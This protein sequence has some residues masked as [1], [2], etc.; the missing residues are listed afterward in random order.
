MSASHPDV[1]DLADLLEGDLLT[2]ERAAQLQAHV[3]SCADCNELLAAL[4]VVPATLA[5]LPAVALPPST[6]LRLDAV[7]RAESA[8]RAESASRE[9]PNSEETAAV[10]Q[11]SPGAASTAARARAASRWSERHPRLRTAAAAAA[12]VAVLGGGAALVTPQLSGSSSQTEDAAAGSAG[13]ESGDAI[14]ARDRRL[15]AD[16]LDATAKQLAREARRGVG[17]P[18]ALGMVEGLRTGM[19]PS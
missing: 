6:A 1:T 4:R 14:R 7:L 3:A 17:A 18:V 15:T 8:R 9:Q 12:T 13:A 19:P 16:R 10:V 5:D 11:M 2:P